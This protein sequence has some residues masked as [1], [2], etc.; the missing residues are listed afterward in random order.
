MI[1]RKKGYRENVKNFVGLLKERIRNNYDWY[2]YEKNLKN[3]EIVVSYTIT[4]GGI[5]LCGYST[6]LAYIIYIRFSREILKKKK[7]LNIVLE[8]FNA[9]SLLTCC[10]LYYSNYT[11]S[12]IFVKV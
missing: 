10:I 7:L 5:D 12:F 8:T 1:A 4:R 6:E 11:F 3:S 2:E 9:N